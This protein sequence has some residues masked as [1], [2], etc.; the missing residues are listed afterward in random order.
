[1]KTIDISENI[2]WVGV[3]DTKIRAFDVI[4]ETEFGTTYNSYIVKGEERIVLFET[5]KAKFFDEYIKKIK[6]LV[7]ISKIEYIIVSHTE[8]DHV[9]SVKK[10]LEL[11][12]NIKIV[13]SKIGI[14]YLK[15]IVNHDF[16]N[17]VVKNGEEI[18]LGGMTLEFILAPF[19]HWPDSMYTYIKEEKALITCDSF[20]AHY[21]S[22]KML[23]SKI[24]NKKNYSIALSYYFNMIM[25]PF[26][27]H[28]INAIK[29]IE[30]KKIDI[31]LTGHGP[32]IDENP[33]EIIEKY[34]EWATEENIFENKTVVMPYVSAYGY[35]RELAEEIEK[36][37]KSQGVNVEKYDM[38]ISDKAMVME[39]IRWADGL[40]FGSPTINGDALPPIWDIL[41]NMSPL[42][43]SRKLAAA[44]GSYAWSGEAVP[45]ME[46]R[47]KML[48]LKQFETGMKIKLKPSEKDLINAFEFGKRF[49]ETLL[50]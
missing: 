46:M 29:K 21:S 34:K 10:M 8:P 26:K 3:Q 47:F 32:I 20:G 4:M 36:G 41:M 13:G 1:M 39:S 7:D 48:R 15:E 6:S 14:D 45:N 43:H 35:T 19:L 11:N 38:E 23:L 18:D 37:L 40:L 44:F 28:V 24:K 16:Q 27:K 22:K 9:G 17:I 25:S 42:V 5:V 33:E 30:H 31:I 49:G 50:G 2:K 12:P